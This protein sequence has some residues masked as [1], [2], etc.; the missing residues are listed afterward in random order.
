MSHSPGNAVWWRSV[1][2]PA[3]FFPTRPSQRAG[4]LDGWLANKRERGA[5]RDSRAPW[6]VVD[7]SWLAHASTTSWLSV[8][9]SESTSIHPEVFILV[10]Y[11]LFLGFCFCLFAL[12]EDTL[13]SL[14]QVMMI[15]W[16]LCLFY[17]FNNISF[18]PVP[19]TYEA[20]AV[21]AKVKGKALS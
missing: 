19:L 14:S 10:S 12:L 4:L 1:S 5:L 8:K 6:P 18:A 2:W 17:P 21:E 20:R 16:N 7:F 13:C 11:F 9:F 3:R 15:P